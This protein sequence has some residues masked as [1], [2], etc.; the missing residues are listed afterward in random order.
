[1]VIPETPDT[2]SFMIKLNISRRGEASHRYI[3]DKG[4]EQLCRYTYVCVWPRWAQH[5]R[6]T[7]AKRHSFPDTFVP[8]WQRSKTVI[9]FTSSRVWDYKDHRH[10]ARTISK[11][12]QQNIKI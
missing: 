2:M 5:T 6:C 12:H 4:T 11:H 7:E 10:Y 3:A 1:L 9:T 8:L